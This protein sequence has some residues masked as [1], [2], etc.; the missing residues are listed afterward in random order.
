M[1]I[2]D[3]IFQFPVKGAKIYVFSSNSNTLQIILIVILQLLQVISLEIH[4][5]VEFYN[6][7]NFLAS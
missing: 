3:F 2:R 5:P 7:H 6:C 4:Y 1:F